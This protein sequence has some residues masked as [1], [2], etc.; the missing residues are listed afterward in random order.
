MKQFLERIKPYHFQWI[1]VCCLSLLLGCLSHLDRK[2]NALSDRLQVYL[3]CHSE[4]DLYQILCANSFDCIRF[5]NV[6]IAITQI[7]RGS[8]LLILAEHYPQEATH[9]T[10]QQFEQAHRKRLR[11]Y[12]EYPDWLPGIEVSQPRY[13]KIERTVVASDFFGPN[14]RKL[15]IVSINSRHF[16]S[17]NVSE[18]HMV[19]A[20]VAGFDTAVYGLPE[21]TFPVLFEHPMKNML[22]ATAKLSNFVTG[23]HS[24]VDAVKIMWQ[25]ILRWLYRDYD[26]PELKWTPTVRPTYHRDESLPKDTEKQALRRAMQWYLTS[27]LL[28]NGE[29]DEIVKLAMKEDG[30]LPPPLPNEPFGNGSFGVLQCYMSG[31]SPDGFQ[32]R[33]A[34]RRGDNNCEAAMA[35]ALASKL[36]G[37]KQKLQIAGNIL[38]FYL[39]S[40]EARKGVRAD[41]NHGAY[42][43]IAW[44]ID[45]PA[46]LRANYGDDNARQ[47][48]GVLATAAITGSA[49]W[50][51]AVCMCMLANL[52]TTGILG[53]RPDRID[54]G[55][56]TKNGW[57]PYFKAETVRIAPHYQAYLWACFLW[58]Y[59]HT[60]DELFYDRAESGI[61]K[62]MEN[63]PDNWSWT[64]GISQEIARMIL[65]LAW[66]VRV[67]DTLEHRQW[68]HLIVTDL[69][70]L[71]KHY[72]GIREKL[73]K[74]GKGMYPPPASNQDYGG[75]EASL[76][77][78]N[79]DPVC[80]L[81]YTTNF[82]FLGLHEA[83]SATG[84]SVY[85]EAENKL[86]EFLCRIQVSSQSH[87]ELDG[88]WFRAFD[89]QRW[90]HWGSDADAGW[91]AWCAM[92]GWIHSWITSVLAMR[93][94]NT[95]L[96]DLTS[97]VQMAELHRKYRPIMIPD[98]V[99]QSLNKE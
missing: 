5:D 55:P 22:I 65:P 54:I 78:Q 73:G 76:I 51:E 13:L 74:T 39:F 36:E 93:Q 23:R 35:F 64:N 89:F 94:M 31:I 42:G 28:P 15:R 20:R 32:K 26:I 27:G 9:I 25:R 6:G 53:F 86:A 17:V 7:P 29:Q 90:E 41:P 38:D 8:S 62:T 98:K 2:P 77:Q 81:L 59:E 48:M 96:W 33:N 50:N 18:T 67:K 44:G 24:P 91:G 99:L 10:A 49:R 97:N 16:V 60:G 63:Y 21:K 37:D 47:M 11:L 61:R 92:T 43:L 30:L 52:R 34:V 88:T 45:H 80:D 4:N 69:I 79:G 46:W 1:G 83:A 57:V 82:A 87:P 14:L 95:S 84:E 40:S 56:L 85:L 3:C 72:G 19:A 66:L 71:Q 70:A 12:I 58:A 68:L 75:T